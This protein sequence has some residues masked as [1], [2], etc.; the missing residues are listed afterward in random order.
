MPGVTELALKL[1]TQSAADQIAHHDRIAEMRDAR[2]GMRLFACRRAERAEKARQ[3]LAAR[4]GEG[5]RRFG[6]VDRRQRDVAGPVFA[7]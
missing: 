2:N 4:I 3:R 6:G 5:Q 7:A 1:A